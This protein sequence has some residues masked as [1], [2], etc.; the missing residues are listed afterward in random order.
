[1]AYF[2]SSRTANGDATNAGA[3]LAQQLWSDGG[4]GRANAES[5]TDDLCVRE[6]RCVDS[7]RSRRWAKV[8]VARWRRK[9][10]SRAAGLKPRRSVRNSCQARGQKQEELRAVNARDRG[11][12]I[13]F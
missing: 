13:A 10:G 5:R 2:S 3:R 9:A 11:R 4:H 12:E 8:C 6:Y 7:R 1:D